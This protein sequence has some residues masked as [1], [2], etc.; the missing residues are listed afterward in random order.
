MRAVLLVGDAAYYGRFGFSAEHDRRPV[1][2]RAPTSAHRLL[3][4]ELASGRAR[5]ARTV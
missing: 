2:A 1:A 4:C 5:T 3:G